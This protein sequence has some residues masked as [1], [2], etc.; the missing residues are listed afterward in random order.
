MNAGAVCLDLTRTV[1]RAGSGPSTGIDR[2]ER[3][4]GARVLR[5]GGLGLVRTRLGFLLLDGPA[6]GAALTW[7]GAAEDLLPTLRCHALARCPR[8]GPGCGAG[9]HVPDGTVYLNVGHAGLDDRTLGLAGRHFARTGVILHDVIPL[10]HPDLARPGMDRTVEAR[11][12]AV[13]RHADVVI[14]PLA[15]TA[16]L[17]AAYLT[18]IPIRVA[19]F[20]IDTRIAD[21]ADR[22]AGIPSDR[23]CF[24]AIGTVEPRKGHAILLD[25]WSA[26]SRT[27][28]PARLPTLVIAGRRGWAAPDLIGR[29]HSLPPGVIWRE[30]LTDRQLAATLAGARAL[31][32]P[33]LA[34]G[35]GF[36]PLEAAALGV[37]VIA[38]P[39]PQ[40]RSLLGDWPVYLRGD[41]IYGW[42][43][44][45]ITLAAEGDRMPPRRAPPA[46][47]G[48][49]RHFDTVL[50]LLSGPAE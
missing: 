43:D 17:I 9:R 31:L 5:D 29:L 26:L 15:P 4:W 2:V 30:D 20:G 33:S 32:F 7:D 21:H 37:P 1:R 41:D 46:L 3:A 47:P 45:V 14:A 16:D 12:A 42:R 48:W 19:P 8:F 11:L 40:T 49:D 25:V 22:P 18:T 36:P 39:L 38:T 34:E 27:V 50:S 6:I 44:A 23:P 10:D 24:V 35:F 28:G 13:R